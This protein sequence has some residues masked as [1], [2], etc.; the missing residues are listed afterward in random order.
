MLGDE[1][2]LGLHTNQR[3]LVVEL[4]RRGVDVELIVPELELLRAS[5]QGHIELLLDRDSSINPY[6]ASVVTADK[7]LAKR[8]MA[9]AGLSVCKGANFYPDQIDEALACAQELGF[10]V[11][12]KPCHGSHGEQVHMNISSL[13][14]AKLA[15]DEVTYRHPGRS[16]LVEEQFDGSEF[17]IFVTRLGDYAVLLRE[18]AHVDGNGSSTIFGLIEAEN[19]ARSARANCLCPIVLDQI[20]KAHLSRQG[21]DL[22]HIPVPGERIYLRSNSNVA[23]GGVCEDYTDKVHPSVIELAFR[24]LATFPGVPFAGIDFMSNDI[25]SLQEP[26]DYRI[27]E[28][29]SAPGLHM[30]MRPGR[31][32]PRNVAAFVADLIFPEVASSR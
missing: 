31:G 12:I 1:A 28:I 20:A 27:V 16:F 24:A 22:S 29:N 21:F 17:R 32:Q 7:A 10:P 11:V 23:Q 15:I 8:L 13:P 2:L 18:P 19:E 3:L 30:H 14:E 4:Q 9:E 26:H 6:A 25:S 5:Y